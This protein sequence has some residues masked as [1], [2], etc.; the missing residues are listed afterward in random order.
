MATVS[1]DTH[2]AAETHAIASILI[3]GKY[4]SGSNTTVCNPGPD[5]IPSGKL[6]TVVRFGNH[7]IPQEA[8]ALPD[9]AERMARF[10]Q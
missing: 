6:L 1:P 10:D 5:N 7:W 9:L 8:L 2:I 4:D 3:H